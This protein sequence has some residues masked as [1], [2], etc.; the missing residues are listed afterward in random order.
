MPRR[1]AVDHSK[2]TFDAD[3]VQ[4]SCLDGLEGVIFADDRD[5]A[6]SVRPERD[7]GDAYVQVT[8]KWEEA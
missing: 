1:E 2:S 7:G 6:V 8:T 4:K 5:V 3:D